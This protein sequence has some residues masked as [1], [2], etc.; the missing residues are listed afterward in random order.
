MLARYSAPEPLHLRSHAKP[1]FGDQA[2]LCFGQP[3]RLAGGER[4]QIKALTLDLTEK[5]QAA[6]AL[7]RQAVGRTLQRP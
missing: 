4:E 6:E 7:A 5:L 1:R 3:L 2:A